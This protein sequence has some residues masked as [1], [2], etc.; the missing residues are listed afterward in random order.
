MSGSPL[1]LMDNG[2][3]PISSR[4]VLGH[5]GEGHVDRPRQRFQWLQCCV[6]GSSHVRRGEVK[7]VWHTSQVGDDAFADELLD[8][9]IALGLLVLEHLE[10]HLAF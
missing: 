1:I 8:H 9:D 7:A 6:D 10:K 2:A 4:F 3:G 5:L